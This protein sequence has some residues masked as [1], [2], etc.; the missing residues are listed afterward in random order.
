VI[1]LGKRAPSLDGLEGQALQ[2]AR[3]KRVHVIRQ[4]AYWV[5]DQAAL[6]KVFGE[7]ATRYAGRPGGYTRII[8]LSRRGGDNAPMAVIELVDRPQAPAAKDSLVP[9]AVDAASSAPGQAE[10]SAP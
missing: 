2:D 1:S 10:E 9:A 4:A 8:K 6:G 7:F 5:H 3:G